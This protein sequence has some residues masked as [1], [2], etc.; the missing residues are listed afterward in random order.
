VEVGDVLEIL[1]QHVTVAGQL[2]RLAVVLDVVIDVSPELGPVP[3]VQAALDARFSR[4]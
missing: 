3:L 2:D 4:A 1:Y